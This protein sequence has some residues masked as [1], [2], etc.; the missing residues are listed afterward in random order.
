MDITS[1][2]LTT[3][4]RVVLPLLNERQRQL[5]AAAAVVMLGHGGQARPDFGGLR[6]QRRT[7]TLLTWMFSRH[8]PGIPG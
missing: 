3:F 1:E 6:P 2:A 4:F 5:V 7:C 8:E